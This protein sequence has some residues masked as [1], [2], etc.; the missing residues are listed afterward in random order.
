MAAARFG[1]TGESRRAQAQR[2]RA[3]A[4][5]ARCEGARTPA[6][7]ALDGRTTLSPREHEIAT[8]AVQGLTSRE[9]A[10]RLV[11]S[12]RTVE[13]HLEHVFEKLGVASRAALRERLGEPAERR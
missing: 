5:A 13:K 10:D 7:L 12:A 9:I 2:L 11:V 3:A 8:L 1:A 6:L 4:L